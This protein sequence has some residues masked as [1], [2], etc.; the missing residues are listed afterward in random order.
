MKRLSTLSALSLDSNP[1]IEDEHEIW[2]NNSD[3]R[4]KKMTLEDSKDS[5]KGVGQFLQLY[6]ARFGY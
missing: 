5:N 6:K 1:S 2:D 4:V 3:L